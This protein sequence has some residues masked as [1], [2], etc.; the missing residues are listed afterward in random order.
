MASENKNFK[1]DQTKINSDISDIEIPNE[2]H[3][4][5]MKTL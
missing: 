2:E 5:I 3:I 4:A 1:L